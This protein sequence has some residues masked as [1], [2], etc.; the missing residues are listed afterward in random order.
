MIFYVGGYGET[1]GGMRLEAGGIS[2]VQVVEGVSRPSFLAFGPGRRV[3]YAVHELTEGR[4]SAFAVDAASGRLT[5]LNTVATHGADPC[6][7][8][9]DAA[10][11]VLVVANYSSGQVT[12]LPI[13]AD[14]RLGEARQVIQHEG[15]SVDPVRQTAAHP[16]NVA[17]D[18][19][20]VFVTDLGLDQVV[21][22][23]LVGG[24]LEADGVA[25][26]CVPGVGPRQLVLDGGEGFVINELAASVTACRY[27]DGVLE[28]GAT[29]STLPP[30]YAGRKSGAELQ[31]GEGVLYASNRGHDSV[32]VLRRGD[33][34]V[35]GWVKTGGK[36][37]RHFARDPAGRY[38]VAA[39]Q[40]SDSLRLFA[41]E[42]EAL[43]DLGVSASA[44]TPVC[45][46]F[47]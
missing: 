6:H 43:R 44:P 36:T 34:S 1:L 2:T 15:G 38:L 35:V 47:L 28:A 4:A 23:R 7:L 8:L 13:L 22:Y 20:F 18:G 17:M 25:L 16:H 10:G 3:L 19:D 30:G 12:V 39:N 46:T 31:V 37:P 29:V 42:G 24:R 27:A 21:R 32:V 41:I 14:G 9:V 33:L 26:R 45:I 40:D 11:L 5:W